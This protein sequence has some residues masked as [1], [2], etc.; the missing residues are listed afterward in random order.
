MDAGGQLWMTC[1][2]NRSYHQLGACGVAVARWAW[3]LFFM[4][5]SV[6]YIEYL[7]CNSTYSIVPEMWIHPAL[8]MNSIC[9]TYNK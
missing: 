9:H 5:K 6:Y 2:I 8:P 4:K 7:Q 3:A 1:S